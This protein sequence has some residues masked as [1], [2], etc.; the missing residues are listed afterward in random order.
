MDFTEIHAPSTRVA[1]KPR[2]FY[3]VQTGVN[4][5]SDS[6][7]YIRKMCMEYQLNVLATIAADVCQQL[8]PVRYCMS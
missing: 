4:D 7:R 6:V 2:F 8:T 5:T 3:V 1:S